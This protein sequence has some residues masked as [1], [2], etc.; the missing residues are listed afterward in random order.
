[1]LRT[2]PDKKKEVEQINNSVMDVKEKVD[3]II[4]HA[5][6]NFCDCE[7]DRNYLM[8]QAPEK[9][10]AFLQSYEEK[11]PAAPAPTANAEEDKGKQAPVTFANVEDYLK[12]VP[13][14][15]RE[16]VQAGIRANQKLR[17]GLIAK[18][19][20]YKADLYSDEELNGMS[21]E[22]MEKVAQMIPEATPQNNQVMDFTLNGAHA[23]QVNM[24]GDA[25]A[26]MLPTGM[27]KAEK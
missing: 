13:E 10:D 14:E 22:F 9:L 6:S 5:N 18:I 11:A 23:P 1:M 20:G 27:A 24:G 4:A 12:T 3:K 2:K 15:I 7:D 8:A 17:A 25:P 26:P 21:T 16:S 19:K